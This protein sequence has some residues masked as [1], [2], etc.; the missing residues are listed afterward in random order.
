VSPKVDTGIADLYVTC[1]V[2]W[3]GA[4]MSSGQTATK[5]GQAGK[6]SGEGSRKTPEEELSAASREDVAPDIC[7]RIEISSTE[8]ID[9]VSAFV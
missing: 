4:G 2:D 9:P 8:R 6:E 1:Q 3:R 7:F 5:A